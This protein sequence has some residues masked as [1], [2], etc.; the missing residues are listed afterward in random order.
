MNVML[1]GDVSAVSFPVLGA[2]RVFEVMG[3]DAHV[4]VW[5]EADPLVAPEDLLDLAQVELDRL[6]R[7]WSRFV[8][9]S[10]VCSMNASAGELVP[11]ASE[12]MD[13]LELASA[14]HRLSGGLFDH[15][16]L[17]ELETAGYDVTFEEVEQRGAGD[18]SHP[19]S[20][21][22]RGR[23]VGGRAS[24]PRPSGR[25][26][27]RSGVPA[28]TEAV[29]LDR[30]QSRAGCLHGREVDLGGIGKGRAADLVAARLMQEGALGACVNLGGDLRVIG[31]TP[32][33]EGIVVAVEH[34]LEV[35]SDVTLVRLRNAAVATSARSRRSWKVQDRTEHHL[36]DPSTGRPAR[37]DLVSVTAIAATAAHAEVVAKVSFL[38][39]ASEASRDR[40][41]AIGRSPRLLFAEDG[42]VT[43]AG[44]FERFER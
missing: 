16:L 25:R 42:T 19:R 2:E 36:I 6:E 8:P 32:G 9:D 31:E 41:D 22:R 20:E 17:I 39:G 33:G 14:A 7:L 43:R 21:G 35:T 13:I 4:V 37:T 15:T 28:G 27:S 29:L 26:G 3:T 23:A 40:S 5:Q 11:V 30:E 38:L 44:G 24:E 1:A 34:P 10:D 18:F 12:T